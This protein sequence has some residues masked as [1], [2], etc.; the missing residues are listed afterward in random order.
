MMMMWGLMSPDV[1]LTYQ[2]QTMNDSNRRPS[3]SYRPNPFP[4]G[5]TRSCKLGTK[6]FRWFCTADLGRVHT[7]SFDFRNPSPNSNPMKEGCRKPILGEHSQITCS[8]RVINKSLAFRVF[9]FSTVALH[10]QKPCKLLRTG[11]RVS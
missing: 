8:C 7:P 10:P 3:V 2:G 11:I 5:Q 1:G 6:M 4:P 9:S